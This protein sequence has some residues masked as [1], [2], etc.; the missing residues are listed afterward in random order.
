MG[1]RMTQNKAVFLD[2]D[3]TIN[4]EIE[5]LHEPS[6]FR[7]IRR[8]PQALM[9]L[10]KAGYLLIIITNQGAIGKGMYTIRD[11]ELTHEFMINKLIKK[12]IRLD[13]IE[14]CPHKEEDNCECRKPK[15]GMLF[16]AAKKFNIDLSAS[17]MVGD[18]LSDI[19]AGD[20]AGT[21]TILVLTGYGKREFKKLH[22][23]KDSNIDKGSNTPTYIAK[24]L[25]DASKKIIGG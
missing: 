22:N 11:M 2:R 17:W 9:L 25:W 13:G 23:M 19:I 20:K 6:K 7:F 16:N 10:K 8:V 1:L 3:G 21:K 18:K 15:S 4:V 12:N 14:Y 5:Y 24:N